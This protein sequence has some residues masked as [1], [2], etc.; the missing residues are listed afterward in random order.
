MISVN[1]LPRSENRAVSRAARIRLWLAICTA[2]A[3]ALG[4]M[5]WLVAPNADARLHASRR[6]AYAGDR[7][8]RARIALEA[9]TQTRNA[10]LE[11]A[12]IAAQVERP[13][14]WSPLWAFLAEQTPTEITLDELSV[15][16]P[17]AGP[18]PE[19]ASPNAAQQTPSAP[20]DTPTVRGTLRITGHALDH[21]ALTRFMKVLDDATLF[22]IVRLGG[23]R[24]EAYLD[25]RA[26]AFTLICEW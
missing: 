21:D 24:R 18:E 2:E 22:R 19:N 26:V 17:N 25:G 15:N 12:K 10:T 23:T 5:G 9:L 11:Q 14:A 4:V 7:L 13:R 6:V 1:L 3:V 8:E 16:V 20:S